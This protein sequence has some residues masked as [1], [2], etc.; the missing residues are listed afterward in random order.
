MTYSFISKPVTGKD[1]L[2]LMLIHNLQIT[3]A[4][5]WG[6]GNK[7]YYSSDKEEDRESQHLKALASHFWE[8]M[9]TF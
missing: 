7:V 4:G 9:S 5:C 6:K 8:E 1:P 2:A 3:R